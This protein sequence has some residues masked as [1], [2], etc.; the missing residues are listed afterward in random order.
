MHNLPTLHQ[1]DI[2]SPL[3][4]ELKAIAH[5]VAVDK[6]PKRLKIVLKP[7]IDILTVNILQ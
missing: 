4:R 6:F 7:P 3:R 1:D 2:N 5:V